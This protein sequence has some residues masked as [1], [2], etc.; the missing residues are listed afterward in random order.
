VPG[1]VDGEVA[2]AQHRRRG[3]CPARKRPHARDELGEHEGLAKVVVR[4]QLQAI[5]PVLDLSGSGEHQDPRAGAR[6]RAT[7]LITV[8]HRQVAVEH[9]H[10]IGRPCGGLQCRPAVV[11]GV[12]GHTSL[13]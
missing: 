6:E 1:A 9:D 4:A 2:A 7:H 3:R 13:P 10:V 12:H 5:D 8:H 11:G